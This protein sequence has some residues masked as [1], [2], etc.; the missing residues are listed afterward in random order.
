MDIPNFR[1]TWANEQGFGEGWAPTTY[2]PWNYHELPPE[3]RPSAKEKWHIIFQ[4]MEFSGV[5][6]LLVSGFRYFAPGN[7]LVA[8][9]AT[10]CQIYVGNLDF[11]VKEHELLKAFSDRR[12][13]GEFL[14][15]DSESPNESKFRFWPFEVQMI[16]D[17]KKC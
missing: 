1:I 16:G 11:L 9:F 10:R 7:F 5:N 8:I 17:S 15:F 2:S 4:P 6:L 3:N 13:A 14:C 12:G